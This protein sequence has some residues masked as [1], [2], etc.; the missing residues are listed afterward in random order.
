MQDNTILSQALGTVEVVPGGST[1]PYLAIGTHLQCTGTWKNNAL[2]R[3]EDD[4]VLEF[5]GDGQCELRSNRIDGD[6]TLL[7]EPSALLFHPSDSPPG[8]VEVRSKLLMTGGKI[9][10]ETGEMRITGESTDLAE[11][12]VEAE[13]GSNIRFL[14]SLVTADQSEFS[15]EGQVNIEGNSTVFAYDSSMNLVENGFFRLGDANG[16]EKLSGALADNVV[17][18]NG[19]FRLRGGIIEV[20][21]IQVPKKGN[22]FPSGGFSNKGTLTTEASNNIFKGVFS[23]DSGTVNMNHSTQLQGLCAFYNYSTLTQTGVGL[24][25]AE[26]AVAFQMDGLWELKGNNSNINGDGRLVLF[27]GKLF[28]SGSGISTISTK[29]IP[30][31]QD[32]LGLGNIEVSDGTLRFT[33]WTQD[34]FVRIKS[35]VW[36]G[37]RIEFPNNVVITGPEIETVIPEIGGTL[38]LGLDGTSGLEPPTFMC[39]TLVLGGRIR[40]GGDEDTLAF[41]LEADLEM[42]DT[43]IFAVNIAGPDAAVTHDQLQVDGSAILNGQLDINLFN[44]YQPAVGQTFTI[45]TATNGFT[46]SFTTI[47][48]LGQWST[49]IDGNDLIL[50]CDVAPTCATDFS[51]GNGITDVNELLDLLAAWGFAPSNPADLNDDDYVDIDDLLMLLASWGPCDA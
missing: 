14:G 31:T 48:G 40:P 44:D 13:S 17:T 42:E 22:P 4:A 24:T 20:G 38:S 50:T 25:I 43:A 15:G 28:R 45:A 6:G 8:F 30:S 49:H 21:I 11:S 12:E 9:I 16:G 39:D 2:F 36:S 3:I 18:N 35:R 23:N 47:T 29:V 33:N 41:N 1:I 37:A 10:N 27:G 19:N 7:F 46:G 51:D 32:T 26:E 34:E 5:S